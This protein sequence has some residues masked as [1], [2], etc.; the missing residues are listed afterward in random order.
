[1]TRRNDDSLLSFAGSGTG[2][3][4]LQSGSEESVLKRFAISARDG[5]S[6]PRAVALLIADAV[7]LE[8]GDEYR[9]AF[10]PTGSCAVKSRVRATVFY[11]VREAGIVLFSGDRAGKCVV[12]V[13]FDAITDFVAFRRDFAGVLRAAVEE[14]GFG[15]LET[16]WNE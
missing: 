7:F 2:A 1:M 6:S 13:D 10:R 12:L 14:L 11:A 8:V 15:L 4:V 16:D 9:L 3:A 5:F